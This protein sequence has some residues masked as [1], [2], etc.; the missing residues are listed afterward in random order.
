MLTNSHNFLFISFM[1][2]YFILATYFCDSKTTRFADFQQ[3]ILFFSYN[4]AFVCFNKI[5]DVSSF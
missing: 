4:H 3:I 5:M 1:C 2:L